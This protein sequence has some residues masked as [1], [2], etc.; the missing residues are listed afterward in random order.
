MPFPPQVVPAWPFLVIPAT[1]LH[2]PDSQP[3]RSSPHEMDNLQ[4][5]LQHHSAA[6]APHLP[7]SLAV[8]R[9]AA[10]GAGG[11]LGLQQQVAGGAG[12]ERK[13]S[14]VTLGL[15]KTETGGAL[16]PVEDGCQEGSV[17][18]RAEVEQLREVSTILGQLVRKVAYDAAAGISKP[19]TPK[20]ET[21]N[22]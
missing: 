10:S 14:G 19:E 5:A 16:S 1:S 7:P 20:L 18:S 8:S 15:S 6:P 21:R 17:G 13:A 11:G 12:Q 22:P 4:A 2:E 9:P 3:L